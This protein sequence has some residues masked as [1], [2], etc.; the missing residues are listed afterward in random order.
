MRRWYL[1]P[2]VVLVATLLVLLTG[3]VVYLRTFQFPAPTGPYAVGTTIL[4]LTD[5]AR[6]DPYSTDPAARREL[7]VQLW[8]PAQSSHN[9][10]ARYVRWREAGLSLFY[11][12]LL[13]THSRSEAPVA[14]AGSPFPVLLFNHRWNGR[15]TQ[16]TVLAEDLASH[17]YVVA[18]TDYPHNAH[19]VLLENGTV[20]QGREV[21]QGPRGISESAPE[22]IAFW[23]GTLQLW[24]RDE[25]FV[26]DRLAGMSADLGSPFHAR[27]DTTRAGALGHSFGGAAALALCGVDPR[28][29]AAV[30]LDGWTFGALVD[31]TAAQKVLLFYEGVS[32]QR[33]AQL[34]RLPV[35]GTVGD[36]LD[37]EDFSATEA[38][39]RAYGG[40]RLFMA[41]TQ[42]MDFSDEP[43]LP[44]FRRLAYTGPTA[45]V[46]VNTILRQ[47]TLQFFDQSLRGQPSSLLASS[48]HSF[49]ELT[50]QRWPA[51]VP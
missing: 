42:H 41:G 32:Q 45:P 16:N 2:G 27:L 38:S 46:E 3:F 24:T 51:P 39:L 20:I 9:R 11:A 6:H 19:R 1:R 13:G 17:G 35:P 44:P 5:P 26:L 48:R 29:K 49:P 34:A 25:R 47:A 43:L 40:Y 14:Q 22:Q 12:P 31:R 4:N 21:L 7:V 15:R 8:Y 36:Q 28:I 33:E 30:N 37:R 10:V 50:V 18:S 23:N